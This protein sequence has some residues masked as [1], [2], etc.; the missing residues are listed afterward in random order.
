MSDIFR[1]IDEELRREN[2]RQLW[3]RFGKY[4]IGLAVLAVVA[5]AGVMGWR[6][7]QLHQRQAQGVNYVAA[8]ELARQGK[9]AEAGA[10]FA[11]LAKSAS[12]GLAALAQLEAGA[13]KVQ[14]GDTAGAIAAYDQLAADGSADP[15]FR[16]IAT[17]LAAR[18]S[19]DKGDPHAVIAQLEPLTN[20]SNPWHGLAIELRAVAEL[21][22]GDTAKAR[23]DFE[24]LT[25]DSTAPSG[26]RQ[27]ALEMQAALAP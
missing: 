2:I 13:A 19:L 11:Q 27:R 25:K 24:A 16:D 22:A 5:T 23:A 12:G 26:V 10:A 1:E 20:A 8:L 6:Q 9:N 3:S 18:Y 7:Y 17:L 21:K 14:A 15:V 4:I